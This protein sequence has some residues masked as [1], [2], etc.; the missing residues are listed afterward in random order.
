MTA[1]PDILRRGDEVIWR[2]A[3]GS[4]A[5]QRARVTG[6]EH[7]RGDKYG[8]TVDS[9]PWSEMTDREYAVDL[10]NGHWAYADQI[11]PVPA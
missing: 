1:T 7:T 8:D 3:W 5:P 4:D 10:D 6:I 11:A 9:A 2:G